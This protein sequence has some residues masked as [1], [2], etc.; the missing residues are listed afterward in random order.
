MKF[1]LP[2]AL[3]TLLLAGFT[4]TT[5]AAPPAAASDDA[6]VVISDD[7]S[8][9]VTRGLGSASVGGAYKLSDAS[10][11]SVA[12]GTARAVLRTPGS[13]VSAVSSDVNVADATTSVEFTLPQLPLV[14]SGVYTNLV[15][16]RSASGLYQV[17]ARVDPR[18]Q[19]LLE[20]LR[21]R[22]GVQ[23]SLRR[24]FVPGLVV[25]AGEPF[26]VSAQ[27][28]GTSS[29]A[30]DA[31]VTSAD[32]KSTSWDVS[33]IDSDSRRLADPGAFGVRLYLSSSSPGQTVRFDNIAV[34]DLTGA[35]AMP[36]AP[37]PTTPAPTAPA[38]TAPAPTAPAPTAPAPTAPAPTT[39]APTTPGGSGAPA[40]KTDGARP[41]AGAAPVGSIS[42]AVPSNAVYVA[43]GAS[44][45][46]GTASAPYGSVQTAIDRSPSGSVLVLRKGTYHETITVPAGK[47]LT[48]QS[49]PGEAVWF[50]GS[51]AMTGWKGSSSRWYVDGWTYDFDSSPTFTKGAAD[52]TADYWRFVNSAYPMAAHPEQVWID[53]VPQ[54]EVGSLSQLTAGT[55]FTDTAADRLYLGTDPKGREVRAATLTKAMS[56]RGEGTIVRGLGI[57]GYATSVWMMG[58]VTAE[59]RGI[60]IENVELYDSATTGLFVGAANVIVRDVTLARN[61][62]M[63][64]NANNADGMVVEG[65][66]SVENNSEHFNQSPVSG[67]L[68][69]T[70]TR[71]VK[72][73]GSSFLR[74]LGPGAW[75]DES[76]YDAD[77][78]S[79][80]FVDNAGHGV[81]LELSQRIDFVDNLLLRNAGNAIK[82]NNTGGIVL[83]NNTI[84]GGN[85]T[86]NIVQDARSATDPSVPGHDK[87]Q[88]F[89]D[90]TMP[91]LIRDI[92]IGNNIIAESSGN[93]VVC[94][95]DYSK[96]YAAS[97]LNIRSDGNLIQRNS[98]SNP[99]WIA[100]WSRGKANPNPY[101][102]TT[103]AAYRSTTG[104]EQNSFTIE[105]RSVTTGA[106][107]LQ[108]DLATR[109]GSAALT[110]PAAVATLLGSSKATIGARIP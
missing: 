109:V 68:K 23:Q 49:Y 27:I 24:A 26:T 62:L 88:P 4:A 31:R 77:I 74:N 18:G 64:L 57:R 102:F 61:G 21:T 22:D 85:R 71:G 14:G 110:P 2:T 19:V 58:A 94:V 25:R 3:S 34:H 83:W 81:S 73:T 43:A 97:D 80:D 35:P 55:F 45:G 47:K 13:A 44:G 30:I 39:P 60:T 105:G 48:I 91:W 37:A 6:T 53:G 72:I 95:E 16:R 107:K 36:T 7:M 101:V 28:T 51:K 1:A 50:D 38:P 86:L 69:V 52:G 67:G 33:A 76:V 46:S 8:R 79:D 100:V 12:S 65:L 42:Y 98:A 104:Q 5:L 96:Q 11:F 66:L 103:F 63:G 32:R 41:G 54:R 75:L 82:V 93:C 106:G 40:W 92:S 15:A 56:L 99:T 9:D 78:I 20:V 108:S 87:R 29:V 70:R 17:Q 84:V 89:P 90:P 59:A 10:A